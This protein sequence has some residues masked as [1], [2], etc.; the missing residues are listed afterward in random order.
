MSPAE[1][2]AMSDQEA[3]M[4]GVLRDLAATK[5]FVF[6]GHA[7]VTL[8]SGRTGARYTFRI[9]APKTQKPG[10]A[11]YFVGV[12]TGSDNLADYT[13]LG[14]IFGDGSTTA[15][16]FRLT[17]KSGMRPDSAPVQA[18]AYLI[19]NLVIQGR[20]PAGVTIFHEGRCGRCGRRLT[21]PESI[22]TGFG[23]EC[24][25]ILGGAR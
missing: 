1:V 22:T 24:A 17:G 25:A 20:M 18:F 9:S 13:Y 6:A 3:A 7:I 21:V 8:E 2:A 4:R 11:V 10:Q 14:T 5:A 23:P 19:D 12:L 16:R 15:T